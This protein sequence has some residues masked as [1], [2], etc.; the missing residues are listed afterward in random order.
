VARRHPDDVA[1]TVDDLVAPGDDPREAGA[2]Q[3]ARWL[4]SEELEDRRPF[5][6]GSH[7]T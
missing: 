4:V 1:R 3:H 7:T 6:A 5:D 2:A